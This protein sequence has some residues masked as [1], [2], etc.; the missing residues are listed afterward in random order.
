[1]ASELQVIL[2][3]QGVAADKSKAIIEAFGGPF[4]EAGEILA[5]YKNIVVRGEDDTETM[6]TAKAHRLVLKKARTTVEKNRKALKEDIVKQG[7]AIDGVAKFVKDTIVPAEE[8]LQ[9]QEDYVKI[10]EELRISKLKEERSAV[11]LEFTDDLSLYK[12]TEMT[13]LQF[14]SLVKDLQDAKIAAAKA[15]ADAAKAE[16]ERIEKERLERIEL[17]KENARLREE[18]EAKEKAEAARRAEEQAKL[19]AEADKREALEKA[20][21]ER[22]AKEAAELAAKEEEA[23]KAQAAPDRDK[24]IAYAKALSEVPHPSV[25]TQ[26]ALNLMVTATNFLDELVNKMVAKAEAL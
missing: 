7:R 8:Y 2:K 26:E 23:K 13:E 5:D 10:Q 12:I 25:E 15:E 9:T 4:Q 18:A 22:Q 21:A 3:D 14:E 11:L 1:M 19:K 6:K 24:I 16:A 20:E 17:E